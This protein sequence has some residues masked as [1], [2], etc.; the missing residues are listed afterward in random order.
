MRD[1]WRPEVATQAARFAASALL[2]MQLHLAVGEVSDPFFFFAFVAGAAVFGLSA[3]SI[4]LRTWAAMSSLAAAP[5]IA[6]FFVAA[7]SFLNLD[8][9]AADTALLAYDR[10]LLIALVPIYWSGAAA[11]CAKVSRRFLRAEQIGRAHV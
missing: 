9:I 6:R 4:G 7:G 8:P 3:A 5:F 1:G 2:L 10:N 11:Y